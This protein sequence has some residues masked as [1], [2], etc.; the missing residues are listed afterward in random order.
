LDLLFIGTQDSGPGTGFSLG[1][2]D[3]AAGSLTPPRLIEVASDPSIFVFNREGSRLYTCNSRTPGGLSAYAVDRRSGSLTRLNATTAEGRGPSHLSLD[4][5][6]RFVLDANYGGGYVE[7]F[8]LEADGSLG[9]QTALARHQG[10]SIDPER[11][12]RPYAHAIKTDPTNRFALA[13]DLGTDR[14]VIYRFDERTGAL[15]PHDPAFQAVAPGSGPRHLAWHPDGARLYVVTELRNTVIAYAW[16]A[17]GGTL[18]ERQTIST[19]PA[20]YAGATTAAEIAVHPDGRFVY[21]S[22]RGHDSIAVF[23]VDAASGRLT[24]VQ[25]VSS[26]GRTPR[27]FTFDRTGRW[28]LVANID[29][30]GIAVFSIDPA[31]GRLTL[32]GPPVFAPR[33]HGVAVLAESTK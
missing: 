6:G 14:I 7:V 13:C 10:R 2:F 32:N 11:Q 12:T 22:N 30:N 15:D 26:A 24:L 29:T 25:H 3:P 27:Y 31:T 33:P 21:T 4:H 8:A 5:T 23:A 16:D 9:P 18:T 19:L 17:D 20:G 1:E 28:L